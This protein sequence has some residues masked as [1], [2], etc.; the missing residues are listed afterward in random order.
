M[1]V[2]F[3]YG[4]ETISLDIPD[5]RYAATLTSRMHHFQTIASQQEQV[6]LAFDNPIGSQKLHELAVGKERVV[7]IAS[8]HTRPVP[9]KFIIPHYVVADSA[10]D[11]QCRHHNLDCHRLPPQYNA[12]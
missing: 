4:K 7:I 12:I 5:S 1:E 3:P 8:D 2:R 10:G 11:P 9:S 6:D